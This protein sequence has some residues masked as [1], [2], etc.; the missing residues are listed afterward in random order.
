MN[1]IAEAIGTK[2]NPDGT[3][4]APTYSVISG[5]P[6]TASVANY[7]KVGDALTALSSAVRTPLYFEGDSGEKIDRLLGSTVAV[8]GG[9]NNADK[10]SENNIGVVTDKNSGTLLLRSEERRVG[11]EC[12]SRWSPYH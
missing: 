2:V 12:R 8:K 6:S 4:T 7:N 9:Q 11:K 3:I 1:K 5:D 10:L